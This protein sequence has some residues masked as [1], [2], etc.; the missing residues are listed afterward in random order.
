VKI[1]YLHHAHRDLSDGINQ[2][3]GLTKVGIQE[4]EATRDILKDLD[5]HAIYVGEF[6]RYKLTADIINSHGSPISIDKR[7]NEVGSEGYTDYKDGME[8]LNK[9]THA[10]LN[11][12]IAKH[13][14]DEN[15]L[16][17]TSGINITS[18]INY[19]FKGDILKGLSQVG[20]IGICPIVFELDKNAKMK[21]RKAVGKK[22]LIIK[23]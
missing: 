10:F 22:R 20:A 8:K 17:I 7:L 15:V 5:I 21:T 3:N 18:F 2:E 11:D 1:I 13:G 9:R 16:C 14:N 19:F 4:A 12:I 6:I 23:L